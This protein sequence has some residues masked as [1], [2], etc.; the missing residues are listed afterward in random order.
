MLPQLEQAKAPIHGLLEALAY[1]T[2]DEPVFPE[3]KPLHQIR[4][5]AASPDARLL[6]W[7]APLSAF[8]QTL[9]L[10]AYSLTM[11]HLSP[12]AFILLAYA[13]SAANFALLLAPLHLV[14]E[15]T[16]H[17]VA[18]V[19]ICAQFLVPILF[20]C[21]YI[22]L[23]FGI[24]A[25][26]L[27]LIYRFLDLFYIT[28]LMYRRPVQ[29]TRD[30]VLSEILFMFQSPRYRMTL[31]RNRESNSDAK[32]EKP[33]CGDKHVVSW[34]ALLPRFVRHYLFADLVRFYFATFTYERY[35]NLTPAQF[36]L[37]SIACM[38]CISSNLMWM[39]ELIEMVGALIF[40]RGLIDIDRFPAIFKAP[41]AAT[42]LTDFWSVRWHQ[43]FRSGFMGVGWY[44]LRRLVRERMIPYFGKNSGFHALELLL[45][46]LGV[47]IASGLLHEY[48]TLTHPHAR[49]P[50]LMVVFFILHGLGVAV[51]KT[52]GGFLKRRIT[53]LNREDN[54]MLLSVIG[55]LWT[56]AF[57]LATFPLFFDFFARVDM[58][59]EV[60]EQPGFYTWLRGASRAQVLASTL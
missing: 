57:L 43:S 49:R 42:S 32:E 13:C 35:A 10:S 3:E 54:R 47:F 44:P 5:S 19:L 37:F 45:P 1:R 55:W 31:S 28:P 2:R 30:E 60:G 50:W 58:W 24:S 7:G 29:Y 6:W 8:P 14:P 34:I 46:T 33:A 52:I 9:S 59:K 39:V 4:F 22:T 12:I 21:D 38:L 51:E 27:G 40:N 36:I 11:W 17:L 53:W 15:R 25:F 16:K 20:R 41:W 26:G 56:S 48:V 23:I 18:A